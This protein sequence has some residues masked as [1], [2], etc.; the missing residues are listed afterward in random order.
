[1]KEVTSLK[2]QRVIRKMWKVESE[3]ARWS[4]KGKGKG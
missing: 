3:R 4:V 1:M 2:A